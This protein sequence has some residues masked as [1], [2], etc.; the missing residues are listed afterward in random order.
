MLLAASL[1]EKYLVGQRAG[2]L[3]RLPC[4]I[5]DFLI[6]YHG[7]LFRHAYRFK[8]LLKTMAH[9]GKRSGAHVGKRNFR[10]A[11]K[12]DNAP[13]KQLGMTQLASGMAEQ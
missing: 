4:E 8:T 3:I 5:S 9:R 12:F 2:A 13:A 10:S 6:S 1:F 11:A 7:I